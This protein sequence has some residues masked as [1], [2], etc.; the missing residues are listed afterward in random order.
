MNAINYSEFMAVALHNMVLSIL[1]SVETGGLP[2]TNY[3]V[4]TFRTDHPGTELP[5]WLRVEYPHEMQIVMQHW[6]ADLRVGQAGFWVTLNFNNNPETIY[7][8]SAALTS[9]ADPAAGVQFKF[10]SSNAKSEPSARMSGDGDA[11]QADG[12]DDD[13]ADQGAPAQVLSLDQFRK[14]TD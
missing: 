5:D 3:F 8:P 4:M 14:N 1:K 12:N 11:P 2:E 10:L 7:V 13:K 9:F 6:F